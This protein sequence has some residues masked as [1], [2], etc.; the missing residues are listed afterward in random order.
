MAI[1]AE[2]ARGSRREGSTLA[3]G[4]VPASRMLSGIS[5]IFTPCYSPHRFSQTRR[6]RR[7]LSRRCP[8]T[9]LAM[10]M[11]E[12]VVDARF[13]PCEDIGLTIDVPFPPPIGPKLLQRPADEPLGKCLLR[14]KATAE[15]GLK[16]RGKG[17]K[18]D[19]GE[20]TVRLEEPDGTAV[21]DD[22]LNSDAWC[23]QRRLV[24]S[25]I[26]SFR[27]RVDAPYVAAV[28]VAG[29]PVVGYPLVP[30]GAG[31]RFCEDD[32]LEWTWYA[33]DDVVGVDRAYTPTVADV[34]R[35][36]SVRA[37]A[38]AGCPPA[39]FVCPRAVAPAP[40]RPAARARASELGE[41]NEGALRV[42]T[43][44]VLADAYSHTWK[45]LY[46][47]LS[48]EA[49][50]AEYRLL[51]AMED[52]RMASPDV[53]ALQEVDKKWYD[54]F[55][56][57]QMRAAGYVPA[58]GLTEKTGL[59]REGCATFCR[60]DAWRPVRTEETG[61]NTPGPMPEERDTSDWV[62]SQPHLAH[63]LSKVNTV[64][65]L[66]VLESAA[67]DGRAVVV[68]NTHLFFHPGAVHLRVMQARWLLRHADGLRRRWVEAEGGGKEVGLVV[69]GDFNGEP[70]D[71]VIR[72]VRES[73]LGAGDGD[74]ALGSVFRWGGTSSRQAAKELRALT[75]ETEAVRPRSFVGGA[76]AELEE[77]QQRLGRMAGSW[78][79]VSEVERGAR[80]P[81]GV[82]ADGTTPLVVAQ[83]H[84][85][86]GCTFKTCATVAAYTLRRDAGMSSGV[87]VD[88]LS[89]LRWPGAAT[90]E[91]REREAAGGGE[92]SRSGNGN[93]PEWARG[94]EGG[95]EG[96]TPSDDA[97]AAL[98]AT[99]RELENHRGGLERMRDDAA[100]LED[101]IV[102]RACANPGS[103]PGWL[104]V[105][106][107]SSAMHLRHPLALVS[108]CG[109]PEFTNYVGGFAGSLDYVWC[110]SSALASVASMPMPPL[111]SVTAETALP[112]SEF[113]S[114]HLP[115]VADL[116]FVH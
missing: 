10:P 38:V 80:S 14:M 95:V 97:L 37:V 49:A 64:A 19:V 72:F 84:A 116:R 77:T 31:L 82:R 48:D 45:E 68:A 92:A 63:A 108:A 112:N 78:R 43:Y 75:P 6:A 109:Y 59:T 67:G 115:M 101:E 93:G 52:V 41:R 35:V 57:P 65:Q 111:E 7:P 56:V 2:S 91:E 50:D 26:A 16:K 39:E 61:L 28:A 8:P 113:P 103:S 15:K 90:A 20:V 33:D 32:D 110:D 70:F 18:D 107:G 42:M 17:T 66:A 76:V 21:A 24:V 36:L 100:G 58:G 62:S 22:V 86:K 102:A 85:E 44:N 11:A 73:V 71:G 23:H 55:W 81:C 83:A 79:V 5:R 29:R 96:V 12:G 94:D 51:L 105:P 98:A 13:A 74:W 104:A 1:C 99:T 114:D 106:V 40:S 87:S 30:V 4:E 3:V 88:G 47:Y 53:V 60:G 27:V 25:P 46:P 34:G 54:A 69:C 9:V 89:A